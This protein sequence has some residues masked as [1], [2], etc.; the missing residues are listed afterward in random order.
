VAARFDRSLNPL[1]AIGAVA[2]ALLVA[3]C[4]LKGSLDP[5]PGATPAQAQ[6]APAPG[7]APPPEGETPPPPPPRKTFFLDFLLN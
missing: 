2:L 1:A 6:G 5:P 7:V 4:G 3:G